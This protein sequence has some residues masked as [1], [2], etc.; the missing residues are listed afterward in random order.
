MTS[1]RTQEPAP[2]ESRIFRHVDL[3]VSNLSYSPPAV[4]VILTSAD[5]EREVL[6]AGVFTGDGPWTNIPD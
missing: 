6:Y 5:V 3:P 1:K 2:V 4:E